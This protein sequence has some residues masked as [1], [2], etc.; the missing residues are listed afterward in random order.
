[1][2]SVLIIDD[3]ENVHEFLNLY[4]KKEGYLTYSAYN[5][6]DGLKM[7]KEY[8]PSIIVLDVMMPGIDGFDVCKIIRKESKTPIIMLTAKGED[9]DKILGLEIGA[10]DYITKPFNPREVAARIK[11]VLRR[12]ED[13][14]NASNRIIRYPGLE[15][16]LNDYSVKSNSLPVQCTSKE[17]EILWVMASK[18]NRVFTREQLLELVWGYEYAG[19]T[20]TVDTHIKRIRAKLS[21]D[22]NS[23]WDIKTV[24]G[25][26]YKFEVKQ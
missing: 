21:I 9:I 23:P 3:D 25:V 6:S 2:Q 7:F 1:M 10:D 15:I 5:G 16:N 19:E 12:I 18:P 14:N 8:A 11:A 26:G 20:R 4:L 13:F 24:W 22:E 17:I